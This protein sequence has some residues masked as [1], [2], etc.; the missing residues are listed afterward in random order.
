M[1]IIYASLSDP[2]I[3]R[4]YQEVLDR[5]L[6]PDVTLAGPAADALASTTSTLRRCPGCRPTSSKPNSHSATACAPR[7]KAPA[8]TKNRIEQLLAELGPGRK[9]GDSE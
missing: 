7:P 6:G 5:H 4:Q 9:N 3:K 1:S 2:T 8:T